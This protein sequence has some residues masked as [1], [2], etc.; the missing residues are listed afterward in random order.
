MR[1][2][3]LIAGVLSFIVGLIGVI[4]P[5]VPTV[6]LMLLAA[7]F[8]AKSSERLHNWLITH[9]RFGPPIR[10]WNENRAIGKRG[11]VAATVSIGAAF[12]ISVAL[13]LK[14]EILI[15]QVVTLGLVLIFIWTRP[16]R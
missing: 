8:L 7:F 9:P 11:K 2:I 16:G 1:L 12:S 4:L 10:D 3:W 15:I 5:L 6:P 14:P 13:D